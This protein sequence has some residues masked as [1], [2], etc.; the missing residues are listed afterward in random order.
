MRGQDRKAH[1]LSMRSHPRAG[2]E[3]SRAAARL[4]NRGVRENVSSIL[5]R[6]TWESYIQG[7]VKFGVSKNV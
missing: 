7:S 2:L 5:K 4:L 3:E 1:Y 6:K